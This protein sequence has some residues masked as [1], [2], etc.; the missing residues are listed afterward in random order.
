MEV[1]DLL[2]RSRNPH[3]TGWAKRVSKGIKSVV[4]KL[5]R[6]H[7]GDGDLLRSITANLQDMM[8][9]GLKGLRGKSSIE[10]LAELMQDENREKFIDGRLT[11]LNNHGILFQ[12][13]DSSRYKRCM[14]MP[15]R[16]MAW[17]RWTL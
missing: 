7:E 17:L 14:E 6:I 13:F 11:A 9:E 16:L 12:K 5:D 4:S 8:D 10:K 3:A 15:E 1:S 2:E